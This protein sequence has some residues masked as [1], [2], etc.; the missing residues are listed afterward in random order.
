MGSI[1]TCPRRA[2][3]GK[4]DISTSRDPRGSPIP[5]CER[6]HAP[7]IIDRLKLAGKWVP[8]PDWYVKKMKLLGF[9]V[10]TAHKK[11]NPSW[12]APYIP[13]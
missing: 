6:K 10:T 4:R 1:T 11:K 2:T 8:T 9:R 3:T 7:V 5:S 12:T 13:S